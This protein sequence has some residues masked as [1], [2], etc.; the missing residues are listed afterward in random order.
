MMLSDG[1]GLVFTI[2]EFLSPLGRY[3]GN[4]I[5]PHILVSEP[6]KLLL[7]KINFNP[8]SKKWNLAEKTFADNCSNI[9]Q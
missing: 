1:S 8:V 4:G 7:T 5:T 6:R 9:F 3:M 2:R